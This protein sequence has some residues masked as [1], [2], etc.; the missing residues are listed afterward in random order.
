MSQ[1]WADQ[2]AREAIKRNEG[3]KPIVISTGI[4]PSGIIHLGNLNDPIRG[5][6]IKEAI[7]SKGEEVKDFHWIADDRDPMKA[8]PTKFMDLDF[9]IKEVSEERRKKL[10]KYL[11]KPYARI[12]DPLGCCDSWSEHYQNL[13]EKDFK[14]L[15]MDPNIYSADEDLYDSGKLNESI[16][17]ALENRETIRNIL[18]KYRTNPLPEDWTIID[19]ICENCGNL[20]HINDWDNEK[21][22]YTC[23]GKEVKDRKVEGC[24]EEGAV[25]IS[26]GK[27]TWR[28]D[29]PARW[30]ALGV[31]LEPFGKDHAAAGGSYDTGSEII[32]QV[33]DQEPPIPLEYEWFTLNGQPLSSSKGHL[34]TRKELTD[35]ISPE[36]LKYFFTKR[37]DKKRDIDLSNI[38]KHADQFDLAEAVYFGKKDVG[39]ERRKENMRRNYE[40]SV[41][42]VPDEKPIRVQYSMCST[43]AQLA[44]NNE[45]ILEMLVSMEQIPEDISEEDKERVLERVHRSKK[46]IKNYAKEDR[47]I[48]IQDRVTGEVKEKISERQKKILEELRDYLKNGEYG[49]GEIQNRIYD[50]KD[51]YDI[52]AGKI[53]QAIYLAILGKE[54]GPRAGQLIKAVGQERAVRILEDL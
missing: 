26:E 38:S 2:K 34:I 53:F 7:E 23:S 18:K 25:P 54:S 10:E 44:Q 29:W 19:A 8:V 4:T 40:L 20:T 5:F 37:P 9:E 30:K 48:N 13:L 27:L 47:K 14:V 51:E 33:Y 16:V 32:R 39:S 50:M 28:V 17:T 43:V 1:H 42:K 52:S 36:V 41:N 31:T 22:Y 49:A 35:L 12:P 46:W 45:D 24:G 11:G 3:G 21:L 15:G 6:M